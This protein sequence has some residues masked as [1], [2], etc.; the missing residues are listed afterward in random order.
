MARR[1]LIGPGIIG[2]RVFLAASG[3]PGGAPGLR[4]PAS[5]LGA[6]RAHE[7]VEH[8]PREPGVVV[9]VR[10]E[11]LRNREHPLAEREVREDVIREARGDAR[12]AA[13]VARRAHAPPL[14]SDHSHTEQPALDPSRQADHAAR[15]PDARRTVVGVLVSRDQRVEAGHFR[16]PARIQGNRDLSSHPNRVW[17]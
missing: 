1:V 13:G 12:H 5:E 17:T 3:A 8:G 15:H 4:T 16:C 7:D 2:W 10:A 9:Q 14:Q 11:T 6:D